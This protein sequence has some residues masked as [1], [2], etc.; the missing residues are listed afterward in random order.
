LTPI[1]C[2][3]KIRVAVNRLQQKVQDAPLAAKMIV[4]GTLGFVG[5]LAAIYAINAVSQGVWWNDF[6]L[7]GSRAL[8]AGGT[9]LVTSLST[10]YQE[11][12]SWRRPLLI[13][14]MGGCVLALMIY[15]LCFGVMME[16]ALKA[17]STHP[18]RF[19]GMALFILFFPVYGL[20]KA[21][22]AYTRSL[23]NDNS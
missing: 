22:R 1:D 16:S 14:G 7:D 20:Q 8:P 13:T 21:F 19:W 18:A 2:A 11:R 4:S 17:A 9:A 3:A 23:R 5:F 12:G 15:A 6:V 10:L